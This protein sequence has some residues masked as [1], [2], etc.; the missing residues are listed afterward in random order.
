MSRVSHASVHAPEK[1]V[2]VYEEMISR[3]LQPDQKTHQYKAVPT[4]RGIVLDLPKD[5]IPGGTWVKISIFISQV[6]KMKLS[7]VLRL[8]SSYQLSLSQKKYGEMASRRHVT[9]N[10]T[11]E[12]YYQITSSS[13]SLLKLCCTSVIPKYPWLSMAISTTPYRT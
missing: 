5:E 7:A 4:S 2:E 8:G 1:A 13:T 12:D 3:G 11:M 9:Y 10:I 6:V